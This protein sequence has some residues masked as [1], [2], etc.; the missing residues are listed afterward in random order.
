MFVHDEQQAF[1][2]AQLIVVSERD[3]WNYEETDRKEYQQDYQQFMSFHKTLTEDQIQSREWIGQRY[4]Y[5]EEEIGSF[6]SFID[7]ERKKEEA[8]VVKVSI[9]CS[10]LT[11]S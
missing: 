6:L 10:T 9:F 11:C 1:Y 7:D 5:S 2:D 8:R 4:N 3:N